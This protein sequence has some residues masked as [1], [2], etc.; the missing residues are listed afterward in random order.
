MQIM[1]EAFVIFLC[2]LVFI[3]AKGI[4]RRFGAFIYKEYPGM[5]KLPKEQFDANPVYV[6]VGAVLIILSAV[7]HLILLHL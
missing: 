7:A 1:G 4:A 3:F 5:N 6:R 2:V